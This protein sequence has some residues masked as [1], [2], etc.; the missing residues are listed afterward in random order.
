MRSTQLA[1]IAVALAAACGQPRTGLLAGRTAADDTLHPPRNTGFADVIQRRVVS[2]WA[3]LDPSGEWGYGV[4][5]P[6]RQNLL[7]PFQ[8][9]LVL[10]NLTNGAQRRVP[11]QKPGERKIISAGQKLSR[12]GKRIAFIVRDALGLPGRVPGRE[13]RVVDLDGANPSHWPDAG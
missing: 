12:D 9:S 1:L 4:V 8:D 11:H 7:V 13:L 10:L 5:T 2:S 3:A 6:D